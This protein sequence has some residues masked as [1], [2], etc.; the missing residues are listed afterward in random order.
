VFLIGA[1]GRIDASWD[2]MV[3]RDEIE[4]LLRALPKRK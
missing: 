3:T 4:P 1:D 2:T